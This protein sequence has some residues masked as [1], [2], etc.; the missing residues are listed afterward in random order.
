[1]KKSEEEETIINEIEFNYIKN[2]QYRQIHI[3]GSFSGLTP[4]GDITLAF[5]A[6]RWPIPKTSR[7]KIS[8]N[9]INDDYEI[10]SDSITGVV[11]EIEFSGY[12]SVRTA[13]AIKEQLER[14]I[15]EYNSAIKDLDSK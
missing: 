3:D 13:I 14:M 5:F 10:S 9:I 8:N 11:R 12:F 1:M 2:P 6:E 15:E 4:N 7:H